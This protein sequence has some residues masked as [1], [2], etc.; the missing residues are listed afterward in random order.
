METQPVKRSAWKIYTVKRFTFYKESPKSLV[1]N[2][3]VEYGI[4]AWTIFHPLHVSKQK[5]ENEYR[6]IKRIVL[7]EM[8]SDGAATDFFHSN[9][10]KLSCLSF[11]L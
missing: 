2:T 6:Y 1:K 5:K 8:A 3:K 11:T 4:T 9:L 10:L 7:D